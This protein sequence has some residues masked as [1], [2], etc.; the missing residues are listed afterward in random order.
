MIDA[1][2]GGT[3]SG[4]RS[5]NEGV[6]IRVISSEVAT[7]NFLPGISYLD[8][9]CHEMPATI[10]VWYLTRYMPQNVSYGQKFQVSYLIS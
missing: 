5:N 7:R 9:M 10:N 6:E 4:N 1:R 2:L 3:G 8:T